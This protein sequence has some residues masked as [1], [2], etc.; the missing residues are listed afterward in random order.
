MC[1]LPHRIAGI[2]VQLSLLCEDPI[3]IKG[4]SVAHLFVVQ[5]ALLESLQLGLGIF[6]LVR[7]FDPQPTHVH[8]GFHKGVIFMLNILN[9]IVSGA[10]HPIIWFSPCHI[11][12]Q[13]SQPLE[14]GSMLFRK[15]LRCAQSLNF[16]CRC[17]HLLCAHQLISK[18]SIC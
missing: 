17:A 6:Q 1:I 13:D 10:V 5:L 12:R 18:S 14:Y 11:G 9:I 8:I 15:H 4:I 7:A 2:R 3:K 16:N